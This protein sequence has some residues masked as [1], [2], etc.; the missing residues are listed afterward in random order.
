MPDEVK[1]SVCKLF[2]ED[3]KLHRNVSS[4][5]QNDLQEDLLNLEN[6]S[7]TWQ[8]HFNVTKCL[9]NH[10]LDST[11]NEKD[12]GVIIDNELKY[13]VHAASA[14][15]KANQVL[16]IIKK[17]YYTRDAK[18]MPTLYKSMA[19]P[20]LEYGNAIWEPFYKKDIDMVESVQKRAAKLIDALKDKPYED[21]LIALDLPSMTYR[22]KR[23]DMILMYKLIN[24]L[25]RLDFNFFFT[26]MGMSHARG[27]SKVF[28]KHA[29]KRP[30]ID[31]FSHRVTNRW[32]SLSDHVIYAPS[33]NIFK[34]RLDEFWSNERYISGMIKGYRLS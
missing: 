12:L 28:K 15:K 2:A 1:E 19:R 32:D 22:R 20:H 31:S 13:H 27:H 9:D 30:K 17:S 7:T 5:G 21:R 24:G 33:T 16:G 26:P 4:S 29:T 23:G 6:W 18:T 8:L 25:V 34:K 10:T 14:T 11:K 3:C